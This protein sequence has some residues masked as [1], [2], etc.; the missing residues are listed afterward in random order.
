[1]VQIFTIFEG[2]DLEKGI[3]RDRLNHF[4]AGLTLCYTYIHI[5][6]FLEENWEIFA[7][8]AINFRDANLG[9]CKLGNT[10][11]IDS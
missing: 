8:P 6:A 10:C 4:I 7:S 9:E 5:I 2:R 11:S 1:M 3:L